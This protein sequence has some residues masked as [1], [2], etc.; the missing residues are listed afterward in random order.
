M[1]NV[2][3]PTQAEV[4]C[5]T[6]VAFIVM[7]TDPAQRGESLDCR[8]PRPFPHHPSPQFPAVLSVGVSQGSQRT[9]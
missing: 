1:F 4:I 3:R 2:Q 8:R 5:H 7:H 6:V 9:D